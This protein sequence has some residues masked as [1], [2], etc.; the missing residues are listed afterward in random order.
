MGYGSSRLPQFD[1]PDV[2]IFVDRMPVFIGFTF[3]EVH[4]LFTD[5]AD[6]TV[7]HNFP[8]DGDSL[9]VV[10]SLT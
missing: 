4:R 9:T 8:W 3:F 5:G 6:Q 2:A 7:G 1:G 10:H